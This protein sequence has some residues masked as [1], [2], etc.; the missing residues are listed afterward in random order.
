MLLHSPWVLTWWVGI[1]KT[2][3][4]GVEVDFP[5]RG[6]RRAP[7]LHL[8][9]ASD[10]ILIHRCW[11]TAPLAIR[12]VSFFR[13]LGTNAEMIRALCLRKSQQIVMV[14][15]EDGYRLNQKVERA[16]VQNRNELELSS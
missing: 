4:H 6:N 8:T 15:V 16:L 5:L 2:R 11:E 12:V 14:I 3:H 9:C 7:V 10:Q 1:V 13:V